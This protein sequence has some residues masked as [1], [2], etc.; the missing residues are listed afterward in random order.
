MVSKTLKEYD[1]LLS[2][3][4]FIRLHQSHLVNISFFERFHKLD[5]GYVIL[6]DK[7]EIPVSTRKK[8]Q[9]MKMLEDL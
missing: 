7:T 9:L 8:E 2:T 4:G 3:H 5:G 1:D 6:K